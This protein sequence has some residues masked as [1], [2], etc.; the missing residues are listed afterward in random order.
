[1]K[2]KTIII[3]S[4][5][6]AFFSLIYVLLTYF[7]LTR[8]IGLYMFQMEGYSKHYK[9]LDKIGEHKIIISMT[10]TPKQMSQLTHTIKSLLDQTVKVDLISVIVPYGDQY[11]LPKELKDSVSV[12][13]CGSNKGLLNCLLPV[14]MRESEST[15]RI[16]TLGTGKAYGKDFIETLLEESD[17]NP[18]NIIYVNNKNYMDLTK[19]IVFSTKFFK[20]DFIDIPKE[21]VNGNKWINDYFKDKKKKR[22]NYGENYK[23]L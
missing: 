2:K 4:L 3:I 6:S 7:G 5:V 14:I 8:Y 15:T 18:D 21:G 22:I 16:I 10:A 23:S 1:M 9:N 11:V 12:F 19:G 13:R 20:E 17:K